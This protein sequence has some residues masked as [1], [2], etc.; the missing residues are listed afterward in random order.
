MQIIA[1]VSGRE[2][3]VPDSREVPARGAALFGAV[4]AGAFAEIGAAVQRTR[5]ATARTFTPDP[6]AAA[7]YDRVYRDLRE[8]H[9]LL[10][11]TRA[12]AAARA[13]A[14][15]R[16]KEGAVTD[17]PQIGLLGIMQ[18]LYDD[19]VPGIT[20]RQGAYAAEVA[21]ALAG[22]ADVTFTASGPQPRGHR[23][24]HARAARLAASTGSRS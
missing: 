16:R 12:G 14:H 18:E 5:P 24:D 21:A 19:M 20:E 15:P 10:G 8:L 7:V 11:R 23:G 2:V 4:A 13:Q 9:D 22:V 3:D 6:G 1:D 17:R